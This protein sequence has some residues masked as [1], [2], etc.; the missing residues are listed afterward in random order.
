GDPTLYTYSI[1][2]RGLLKRIGEDPGRLDAQHLRE[3][4]LEQSQKYG[5]SRAK[6][7]TTALRM[8]VRFLV[9]E[10]KCAVGLDAAIPVVARR[11]L[12]SLPSYLQGEEVERVIASC[13]PASPV[14]KRNRAILLLIARLGLRA[15]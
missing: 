13:D 12:S 9:A 14:G 3:F 8:F 4:V 2:L 1:V 11:R 10:G 15:G 5:A 7:C 6:T